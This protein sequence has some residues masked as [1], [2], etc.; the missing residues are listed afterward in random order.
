M[1]V[2]H[3]QSFGGCKRPTSICLISLLAVLF[4]FYSQC[5]GQQASAGAVLPTDPNIRWAV[6][7]QKLSLGDYADIDIPAG[8]RM[9]DPHGARIIL[10]SLNS[11]VPLNLI[12]V[13]SDA[14][15]KWWAVME[16]SPEG[17]VKDV[18]QINS[19]AVLKTLQSEIQAG[20]QPK[21]TLSW[22]SAPV[23]DPQMHSLSW[24]V[25]AQNGSKI[26]LSQTVVLL[27][28]SGFVTIVSYQANPAGDISPL[29]QWAA[30]INF[31]DGERYADFQSGDQVAR[32]GLS[33]LII[34]ERRTAKAGA[35]H[36]FAGATA[37][38]YSGIFVCVAVGGVMLVRRRKASAVS[39]APRPTHAEAPMAPVAPVVAAN[40]SVPDPSSASAATVAAVAG[41][42]HQN[43][44]V[45]VK[46]PAQK[47]QVKQF[48][49]NRRKKIFNYPK[50]YTNVMRELSMHSYGSGNYLN[51][52]NGSNGHANGHSNGASNGHS[53]GHANGHSNGAASG[54]NGV[55]EAIKAEIAALI[56]NQK[57]LIEEQKCLLEQQTKLI[58]EKRW[59]I[60]EQSAFLKGQSE[61]QFPLKFD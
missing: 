58:A 38:V 10:D 9:T 54:S 18:E 61:Q 34:G 21:A 44:G 32:M 40:P 55:N 48:H 17:F 49:R 11:P 14:S 19:A 30:S 12:G 28:R 20:G 7:P 4:T 53:N 22:K 25:G 15:G 41:N 31:K 50:F 43:G 57:N 1:N 59:L 8:Y 56:A 35:G 42:G 33:D 23:Y 13:L 5:R 29:K 6:G 45:S 37:A 46:V 39:D 3:V 60:E 52:K 51:G 16:Y 26:G 47:K 2:R 27:G 36:G 24:S